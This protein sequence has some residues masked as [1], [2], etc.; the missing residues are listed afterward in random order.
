MWCD[1]DFASCLDTRR[2]VT[3][4]VVVCFEGAV[5]WESCQQPTT[6]AS[7][8]DAEF[9]A[10]GAAAREGI[11]YRKLMR[12]FALLSRDLDLKGPLHVFCDNKAAL[13]LCKDRKE[14]KRVKHIDVIHHF[15]RDRV[16]SG[17]LAFLYF[18]S[19]NNVSD[20]LTKALP[21][22]A[23]EVGLVGLGMLC[24]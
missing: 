19:K 17:E 15:A 7:T 3:G 6:A 12:E 4:W 13:C 14:S 18:E 10:C 5:T 23:F 11:S 1:A 2:S 21:R 24:V 22:S 16:A 9:L 8:M 20:C